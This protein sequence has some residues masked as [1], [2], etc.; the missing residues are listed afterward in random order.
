MDPADKHGRQ[1]KG[2]FSHPGWKRQLR[3]GQQECRA[4]K[5]Q[6]GL[7]PCTLRAVA[8]GMASQPGVQ[9]HLPRPIL[10]LPRLRSSAACLQHPFSPTVHHLQY[11]AKPKA[12]RYGRSWLIFYFFST[13]RDP[14]YFNFPSQMSALSH[15]GPSKGGE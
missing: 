7:T 15:S 12:S 4:R 6:S 13:A 14:N 3:R 9:Q 11:T 8:S 10:L 1:R 5:R 2:K